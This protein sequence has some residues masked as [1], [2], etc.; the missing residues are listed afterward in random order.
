VK[1]AETVDARLQLHHAAQ[2]M[3]SS[4]ISYL[5]AKA[6]DSHTNME[7]LPDLRA[8][9]INVLVPA[10]QFRFALRTE[11][12]TLLS[13]AGGTLRSSFPLDGRTVTEALQWTVSELTREGLAPE[14]L[15]TKKHY[16]IPAHPVAGGATYR[17][18]DGSAFRELAN[19]YDDANMVASAVQAR[20]PSASD[21]RCW[22][23]HF[24]LATLITLQPGGQGN[25][26]TIG[27]GLSPGDDSY[28]EPYFY[29]T[30]YPSPPA[31]DL[32]RLPA[33][34]WHIKGWVGATLPT[35]ELTQA[36]TGDDQE[37]VVTA[38]VDAALV[39]CRRALAGL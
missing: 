38:Y 34:H 6:D 17:L 19:A 15:T 28:A 2:I 11:D 25:A 13:L 22:P 31:A 7:W 10:T 5:P 35:S 30:P 32:P 3:V 39:E 36:A 20:T 9:A 24:D 27:V 16:E 1:P 4:A 8:L 37:A 18:G 12:L 33:G 23:H 29:V 26:R 21:V 14:R